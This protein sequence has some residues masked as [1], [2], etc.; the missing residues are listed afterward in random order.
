AHLAQDI[1]HAL[2]QPYSIEGQRVV[3]GS[4]IGIA[5]CPDD[6]L[7]SESLIRNADLSLYAAKD[8]G[9]GRYHFYSNDL[10]TAAEERSALE[11][12]LRDAIANGGL[13]LFYQP[14]VHAATG[15]IAGFEALLRWNH[16]RRGW[17]SPE[18]FVPIAE[19]TGLIGT[20]GEWA[21]R[22]V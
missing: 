15:Q 10:H 17:L 18:K 5:I 3:I 2:S 1:I 14:V 20:I 16:A 8:A 4:S 21:I 9:R 13:E 11:Q 7:S 22:T 19:D 6:G 12:D